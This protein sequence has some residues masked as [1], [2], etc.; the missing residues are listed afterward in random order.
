[1]TLSIVSEI[2]SRRRIIRPISLGAIFVRADAR[3]A[4]GDRA[5]DDSSGGHAAE[6]GGAISIVAASIPPVS[7][8]VAMTAMSPAAA[9]VANAVMAILDRLHFRSELA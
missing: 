5:S 8:V 4:V 1:M 3:L 2:C 6:N 7:G 9:L